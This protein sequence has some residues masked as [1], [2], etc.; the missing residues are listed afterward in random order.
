MLNGASWWCWL[1]LGLIVVLLACSSSMVIEI[2]SGTGGV[3]GAHEE[4]AP[5]LESCSPSNAVALCDDALE[6]AACGN[7]LIDSCEIC[8]SS[9]GSSV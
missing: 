7:G 3:G 2:S 9:D 4:F 6:M 5:F 1:G 8:F